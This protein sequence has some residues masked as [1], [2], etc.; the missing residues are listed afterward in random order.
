MCVGTDV[1]E[2]DRAYT[3]KELVVWI[4]VYAKIKTAE[5]SLMIVSYTKRNDKASPDSR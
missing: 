2:E 5:V 4:F 1:K 3:V